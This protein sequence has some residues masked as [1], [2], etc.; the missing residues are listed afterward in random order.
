M[1]EELLQRNLKN[2]PEKI[3]KWD[4]YNIGSTSINQLNLKLKNNVTKQQFLN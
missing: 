2:D 4:F 3:G 1:S